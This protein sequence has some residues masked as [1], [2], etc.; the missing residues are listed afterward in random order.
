MIHSFPMGLR[1]IESE[2]PA[3]TRFRLSTRYGLQSPI[4][5]NSNRGR[6]HFQ[7]K[8]GEELW[9]FAAFREGRGVTTYNSWR[10]Q[11]PLTQNN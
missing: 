8:F 5:T 3:N 4:K 1:L 2:A 11:S 9:W 10:S 7:V 6:Q